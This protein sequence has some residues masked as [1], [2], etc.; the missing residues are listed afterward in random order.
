MDSS[1]RRFRRECQPRDE[2]R[3]SSWSRPFA[4]FGPK[5]AELCSTGAMAAR[6][7][8]AVQEQSPAAEVRR[9]AG[10]GQDHARDLRGVES[11]DR[12]G[13]P[14][15]AGGRQ[16]EARQADG[17]QEESRE[18]EESRPQATDGAEEENDAEEAGS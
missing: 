11:R 12:L 14:S 4:M 9:A 2:P 18:E 17:A 15:R 10:Q 1:S 7:T 8:D 5:S 3:G 6:R 13:G 16:E